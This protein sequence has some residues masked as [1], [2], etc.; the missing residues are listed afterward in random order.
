MIFEVV[1]PSYFETFDIRVLRG[2]GLTDADRADA[3]RVAVLSAA[4]A[5]HYWPGADPVGKRLKGEEGTSA[6]TIVG[7]VPETRYRDLRDTRPSIYFPLRQSSFPVAPMTLAIR[8]DARSTNV[9][10]AIRRAIGE[11][12][13]GVALASAAPF[14]TLLERPLAQPRLNALLLAGFAGAAVLLA[15]VGLFGVMATMV[16]LRTRELGV[17]L[18]LGATAQDVARLVLR[19]GM[20]LAAAGTAVGLGAALAVNRLLTALLFEVDPTD[21]STLA[22][23]AMVLLGVAALASL[24]PARSTTRIDPIDV[25]RAD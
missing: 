13:P 17:R 6:I 25:L 11:V 18:A 20:T 22:V 16:R 8:T 7:V 24:V 23:V 15:A 1:T 12:S 9:V 19:R 4:A 3:P 14:E 21:G 5:R 2:R 10:P